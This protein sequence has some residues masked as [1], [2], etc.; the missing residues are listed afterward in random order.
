MEFTIREMTMA[1]YAAVYALWSGTEGIGLSSADTPERIAAFLE[2]NP[3]M[4]FVAHVEGQLVGALLG[5]TDGR[6]GYLH[7][8]AVSPE[9]R[10][11]G[12]G[13]QLV[14]RA[15]AALKQV[16][17]D[18]CHIFVYAENEAGRAFWKRV[19]WYERTEL[20]LMSYD[21]I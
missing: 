2:R 11:A 13:Y 16:G 7:H 1:D 18:R 14:A 20:M 21:L 19:G 3:G 6:R 12:I 10:G 15:L 8:L 4:S 5:G 17:V 9:R